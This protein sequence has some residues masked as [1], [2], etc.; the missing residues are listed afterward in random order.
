[1]LEAHLSGGAAERGL[2]LPFPGGH[3]VAWFPRFDQTAI[4][5]YGPGR[6]PGTVEAAWGLGGHRTLAAETLWPVS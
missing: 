5:R 2:A 4:L 1:L 3:A 6:E